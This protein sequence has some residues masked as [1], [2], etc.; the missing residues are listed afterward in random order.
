MSEKSIEIIQNLYA[1][2]HENTYIISKLEHIIANLETNLDNEQTAHEKRLVRTAELTN[3][4]ELFCKVFLDKNKYYYIP[5][6]NCFYLY[7]S[8]TYITANE[9]DI[10][11]NLLSTIT[12][13][14]KLLEW[15]FKSKANIIKRIKERHLF[16]SVPE[17]YTIQTVLDFL[18]NTIFKSRTMSKYFLTIL[19]DSILKKQSDTQLHYYIHPSSKKYFTL[20]DGLSYIT[21]G[22]SYMSNFIT[23]YHDTHTLQNYRLLDTNTDNIYSLKETLNKIGIDLLCVAT[24]YSNR[25]ENSE[26]FL[27]VKNDSIVNNH[28]LYFAKHSRDN[29]IDDYISSCFEVM[30]SNENYQVSWKNMHYIWK[31]Y[32]NRTGIPNIIYSSV[33]KDQL[34]HKLYYKSE[35]D[36]FTNIV[37]RYVPQISSFLN[38]W[39]TYVS[40]SDIDNEFEVDEINTLYKSIQGN[41]YNYT[42]TDIIHIIKHFYSPPI[43]IIDNKYITNISISLWN[44]TNDIMNFIDSKKGIG[45]ISISELYDKYVFYAKTKKMLVVGKNYFEKYIANNLSDKIY[46]ETLLE[47]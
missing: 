8:A 20:I 4:L 38:F 37:S 26:N 45:Y 13:E 1:K 5:Y 30:E 43:E 18:T 2:F 17:T 3:E 28:I 12:K 47:L 19:G 39:N 22:T 27:L 24:Y 15:K 35:T 41:N 34:K 7:D 33:L 44:K 25:Y 21:S 36:V 42:E 29:I 40:I 23:K 32:L 31:L 11:H 16:T 14:G 9:D 10:H 46:C 6:N